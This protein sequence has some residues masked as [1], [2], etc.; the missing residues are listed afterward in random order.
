MLK[1][2]PESGSAGT[3]I[4]V[5]LMVMGLTSLAVGSYLK[6]TSNAISEEHLRRRTESM[7]HSAI[8]TLSLFRAMVGNRKSEAVIIFHNAMTGSSNEKVS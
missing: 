5:G 2:S 4:V 3:G 1:P 8:N 7:S 6:K